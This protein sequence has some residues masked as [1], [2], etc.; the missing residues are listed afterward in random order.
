MNKTL[1]ALLA[2]VA[3]GILLA[4]DKGSE[5]LKKLRSRVKDYTDEAADKAKDLAGKGKEIFQ[6]GRAQMSD[7]LD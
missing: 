1:L 2:G 6:N 4:P 7:A 3:I 5:T